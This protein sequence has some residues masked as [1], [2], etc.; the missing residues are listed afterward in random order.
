MTVSGLRKGTRMAESGQRDNN[1]ILPT[2]APRNNNSAEW[3]KERG[4]IISYISDTL[5]EKMTKEEMVGYVRSAITE[6]YY[7]APDHEVVNKYET[8]DGPWSDE[9]EY[10]RPKI[11]DCDTKK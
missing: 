1:V 4:R 8:L 2:H 10:Y 9:L 3:K 6:R 11:T 7:Y 5:I